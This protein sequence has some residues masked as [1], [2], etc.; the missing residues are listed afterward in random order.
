MSSNTRVIRPEIQG[1]RAVAVLVVLVFHIWKDIL[2]G[3]YVGVDVFFV[4]S[5]YL[6]TGLL[7]R[8]AQQTGRISLT[9]FYAR[10]IRRLLPASALVIVVSCLFVGALPQVMWADTAKEALASTFY[11]QNWWLSYQAV[12]YLAQ[13]FA[14]GLLR[15]YWSLSVE[16]QYYIFWP[17]M[18][19]LV[20]ACSGVVKRHPVRVFAA[21]ALAVGGVSLLYSIYLTKHNPAFAYFATSTRAWE[22]ALGSGLAVFGSHFKKITPLYRALLGWLGLALIGASCLLF[23]EA[24]AF[25]G[26][27]ALLPTLGTA[28]VIAAEQVPQRWASEHILNLKP[29]QYVGDLSYSIY[30]WHWPVLVLYSAMIASTKTDWYHGFAVVGLTFLLA[31][32]SKRWVEDPFR[33][34]NWHR[35]R[36]I[37]S[38]G[39][40]VATSVVLVGLIA[41]MILLHTHRSEGSEANM[42][43]PVPALLTQLY[44]PGRP[45]VPSFKMARQDNP[46]VYR[47]KCHANQT[48]SEPSS[49]TFGPASARRVVAL[50]GDSHAAQWLPA[51]QEIYRERPDW[52]IVT[53]TKSACAFNAAILSIGESTG[54]YESCSAWN[55]RVLTE[56]KTLRPD[57]V[58]MSASATYRVHG[59]DNKEGYVKA[60]TDGLL[61]RW[62]QLLQTGAKLVAI[63]D[64]PRMAQNIPECMSAPGATLE[65]CSTLREQAL[66]PDPIVFAMQ[67][68]PKNWENLLYLDMTDQICEAKVC[69]PIKGQVLIWRDSGHITA[70][71]S[72]LQAERMG[73]LLVSPK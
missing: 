8:E 55:Q 68:K 32:L 47:L 42:A 53:Y 22:L 34:G 33:H 59:I 57:I 11:V 20:A 66:R 18:Y 13:D 5:G 1:L 73:A 10:R 27:A 39:F 4:I 72:R 35:W 23:S 50:V 37:S 61:I 14:P 9:N 15:H 26:Y 43:K 29:M 65:A 16:E 17:L 19:C 28:M 46:D 54:P 45:T 51:L 2:P 44:N 36:W 38:P 12:D 3:G 70:T 49:C 40:I 24:T 71:F 58:V 56:L 21:I 31:H 48:S 63:R 52:R 25:P 41:G 64:T 67:R 62:E 69:K 6:I 7:L 60:L 30:L